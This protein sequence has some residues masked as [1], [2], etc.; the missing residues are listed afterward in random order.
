MDEPIRAIIVD[1]ELASIKILE[2]KIADNLPYVKIV[3]TAMNINTAVEAIDQLQPDLVFLDISLPDGEG[4]EVIEKTHFQGY[5]IIFVTAYHQYA[6]KAFEFSALHYLVKPIATNLLIEAVSKIKELHTNEASRARMRILSENMQVK[7]QKI[8]I[9]TIDGIEI[10]EISNIVRCESDNNNT[11]LYLSSGNKISSEKGLNIYEDLLSEY[12]FVRVHN[13]HIL[14]L[15]Y[16]IK[17]TKD[18]GGAAILADNSSIEVAESRKK[19]FIE[20]FAQTK[21]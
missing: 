13:K 4:F 9:P 3:S 7:P 18:H 14:N 1:D 20:K 6:I 10:I 21:N 19:Y 2:Q 12:N 16:V 15:Q 11:L 5:E 17:Y 8:I